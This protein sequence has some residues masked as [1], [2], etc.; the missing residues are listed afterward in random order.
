M[1]RGA[2]PASQPPEIIPMK[3]LRIAIAEDEWLI[4]EGL[5]AQLE[6]LGHTVVGVVS[7]GEALVAL[8]AGERPDVALVDMK[9]ARGSDGLAA[10]REVQDRHGVPAVAVTGHLAAE[11]ARRAGLLGLLH[12][13]CTSRALRTV[14]A[15][16][17]AWCDRG[18]RQR[19]A[20]RPFLE[21]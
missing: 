9:L 5:R 21:R 14:L 10:A 6:D 2:R 11:D 4:A 1:D 19:R 20:A 15:E 17:A 3:P 16:A 12:K 7:T 13:P 18:G 8:T